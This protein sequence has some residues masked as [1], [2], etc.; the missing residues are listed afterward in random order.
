MRLAIST[1]VFLAGAAAADLGPL[2]AQLRA[3]LTERQAGGIAVMS[4]APSG[5][6]G[7]SLG[8]LIAD[9]LSVALVNDGVRVVA[10]QRV[11]DEEKNLGRAPSSEQMAAV[12]RRLG[13]G[14][15]INGS[16]T[17]LEA[18][19]SIDAMMVDPA[20]GD[21]VG[22]AS[23]SLARDAEVNARLGAAAAP[24][25][26]PDPVPAA[27]TGP[28]L[29][30]VPAGTMVRVRL[31][32]KVEGKTATVGKT[33]KASLDQAL[34]VEDEPVAA[35]LADVQLR[36][37]ETGPDT[38]ALGLVTIKT[39]DGVVRMVKSESIRQEATKGMSRTKTGLIGAAI[40]AG[41]GAAAGKGKGAAIGAAAGGGTGAAIGGRQKL[42]MPSEM[43]LEFKMA[44]TLTIEKRPQ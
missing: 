41:V 1:F 39:V 5:A 15:V 43:L 11:R 32:D 19:I 6:E 35:R 28:R 10:R 37:T 29:L 40:G 30:T 27:S 26:T 34:T 20:Q 13:V 3:K 33:Y 18:V 23:V 4:F 36:V 21:M 17:A 25:S 44:G 38:M 8:Q 7:A 42:E 24:I 12:A 14:T 9:R 22:G 16:F 31:V 2:A